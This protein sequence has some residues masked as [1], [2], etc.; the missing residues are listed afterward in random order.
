MKHSDIANLLEKGSDRGYPSDYL[1][2]RIR[3]RKAR[4]VPDW[5]PVVSSPSPLDVLPEGHFQKSA[6]DRSPEGIWRALL[7]EYRWIYNQMNGQLRKIF[8]P[9]FVY[10]ELRTLFIC[11]RNV[12]EKKKAKVREMLSV[13]LLSHEIKN[14]LTAGAGEVAAVQALEEILLQLSG[15]FSGITDILRRQGLN[16]F[17]HDLTERFL[18]LITGSEIDPVIRVFFKRLVDARNVMALSKL[19]RLGTTTFHPF[20]PGGSLGEE[21]LQ[22]ILDSRDRQGADRLLQ[23]L[24]GE[25][26]GSGDPARVEA[27]LYRGITRSLKREGRDAPGIGT[28]LDYLWRC[29]IE[30]MNLSVL[31]YG[32]DLERVIVSAELVW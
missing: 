19:L 5:K 26:A 29:S 7:F 1:V 15:R 23:E 12:K 9:F 30:A 14:V 10:V 16:G 6:G 25:E 24:T 31:S 8:G 28:I 13:S 27:S 22:D 3:G 18:S 21:R 11:L 17:E 32:R 4:L 2:S 20:I